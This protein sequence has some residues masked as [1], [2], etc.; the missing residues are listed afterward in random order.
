MGIPNN[1]LLSASHTM[2]KLNAALMHKSSACR[3]SVIQKQSQLFTAGSQRST[4][5]SRSY[6]LTCTAVAG[7]ADRRLMVKLSLAQSS[8][9][10][11]LSE[12]ELETVPVE[13][14]DLTQL[15]VNTC[16]TPK[17]INNFQPIRPI[18]PRIDAIAHLACKGLLADYSHSREICLSRQAGHAPKW[19]YHSS[20][21]LPNAIADF[22]RSSA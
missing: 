20:I 14:C 3:A 22:C 2:A 16:S 18:C 21:R 15:E 8:G 7:T 19:E 4:S 5:C 17:S 12:F 6:R 1:S 13:V 9:T 11:D 10:L